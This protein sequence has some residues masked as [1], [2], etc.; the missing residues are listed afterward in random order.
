MKNIQAKTATHSRKIRCL[1]IISSSFAACSSVGAL[2]ARLPKSSTW[3]TRVNL[4][5]RMGSLA[6]M[7]VAI[8]VYLEVVSGAKE[9]GLGWMSHASLLAACMCI[10]THW[11]VQLHHVASVHA[12]SMSLINIDFT[13]DRAAR[14]V[15]AAGLGTMTSGSAL[16]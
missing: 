15:I 4:R 13:D 12:T 7:N 3:P 8:T 11:Q 16:C 1:T 10:S 6:T 2:R 5:E 9:K 14:Q